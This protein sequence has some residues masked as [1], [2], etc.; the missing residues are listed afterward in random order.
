MV[1]ILIYV[2]MLFIFQHQCKL[3]ICVSLRQ[4]LSCIGVKVLHS[5]GE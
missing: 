4:L 5:K 3:D 2:E 1:K